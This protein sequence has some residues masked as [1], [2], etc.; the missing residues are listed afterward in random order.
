MELLED[1]KVPCRGLALMFD[2]YIVD[3]LAGCRALE[4]AGENAKRKNIIEALLAACERIFIS[5][6]ERAR[7]CVRLAPSLLPDTNS[8]SFLILVNSFPS[9][10]SK[11]KVRYT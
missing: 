6:I 4:N 9:E 3:N 8:V 11:K 7:R 1:V 5:R 2:D 10:I